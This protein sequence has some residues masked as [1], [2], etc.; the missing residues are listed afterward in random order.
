MSRSDR[1]IDVERRGDAF[2]VRLRQ[3]RLEERQIHEVTRELLALVT[4]EGCR[5]LALSLG[6]QPPECLYSV[7]LAKLITV[8]RVLGGL[9][10][11]LVLC[12]VAPEVRAIFEACSLDHQFP[13]VP[14]FDA[15]VAHWANG[16]Q[17]P[18]P[19]A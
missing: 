6:P 1:Y 11:A 19:H 13:F 5:K 15:A 10:G 8:Q 7:F 2:C 17:P 18:A 9:G 14:D 3:H 16:P 4:D 12:E